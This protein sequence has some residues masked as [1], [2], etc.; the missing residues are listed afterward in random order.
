MKNW[1]AVLAVL[2]VL[3]VVV[4]AVTLV[5]WRFPALSPGGSG[6]CQRPCH[7]SL[8]G[9]NSCVHSLE[10]M[11]CTLEYRLGDS[12]AQY[13]QCVD[14]GLS[15]NT[16]TSPEYESCINCYKMCAASEGGFEGCENLCR[17]S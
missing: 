6:L 9:Q 13:I 10:P 8:D 11:M 16:V 17:P 5:L 15:C 1:M 2:A 4:A 7:I 14:T 3:L 12:C